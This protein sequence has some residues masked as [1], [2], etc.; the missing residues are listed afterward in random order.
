VRM[1]TDP[2]RESDSSEWNSILAELQKEAELPLSD[3]ARSL[4]EAQMDKAERD[5]LLL[6]S[7]VENDTELSDEQRAS[8]LRSA[9]SALVMNTRI[10]QQGL[11]GIARGESTARAV[12]NARTAQES[13][14]QLFATHMGHATITP[15]GMETQSVAPEPESPAQD[16]VDSSR[17]RGSDIARRAGI[18]QEETV[19]DA[20]DAG[21]GTRR[22]TRAG[23]TQKRGD[24]TKTRAAR[25]GQQSQEEGGGATEE[26]AEDASAPSPFSPVNPRELFGRAQVNPLEPGVTSSEVGNALREELV[27]EEA[28][29]AAEGITAGEPPIA[30]ETPEQIRARLDGRVSREQAEQAYKD[31]DAVFAGVEAQKKEAYLAALTEY[32]KS[33]GFFDAMGE[34]TGIK[35]SNQSTEPA[36]LKALKREWMQA[37]LSRSRMRLSTVLERRE[38]RG[39]SLSEEDREAKTLRADQVLER[40]QRRY[41]LREAASVAI[42]AA[43]EEAHVRAEALSNRDRNIVEKVFKWTK[44]HPKTMLLFSTLATGAGVATTAASLTIA[45]PLAVLISAGAAVSAVNRIRAQGKAEQATALEKKEGVSAERVAKIRAEQ[46]RLQKN[47]AKTT[48]AGLTSLLFG[49][50]ANKLFG[51]D[52]A[53]AERAIVRA[54]NA[55]IGDLRSDT[56]LEEL[57]R[58]SQDLDKAYA[59][60]RQ[61]DARI[62]SASVVG[63]VVGGY[64]GGAAAGWVASQEVVAG[65]VGGAADFVQDRLNDFSFTEAP[66]ADAPQLQVETAAPSPAAESA[67]GTVAESA[68]APAEG[69]SDPAKT[70]AS[71]AEAQPAPV[72]APVAAA[73]GAAAA[74]PAVEGFAQ[75]GVPEGLLV[76]ATIHRA[77]EGFGDMIVDLKENFREQLGAVIDTPKPA[78]EYVLSANANEITH[79][80]GAAENGQSLTMQMGDQF[81]I[82]ENQNIWFQPING[83]PHLVIENVPVTAEHPDGFV[84]HKL[85]TEGDM[86]ADVMP[87][88]APATPATPAAAASSSAEAPVPVATVDAPTPVAVEQSI[89][90]V[91]V[92][93]SVELQPGITIPEQLSTQMPPEAVAPAV[94]AEAPSAA[95]A[96]PAAPE[97]APAA[98]P[99]YEIV[100]TAHPFAQPD[101]GPFMNENGVDLNKPQILMNENRYFALG[102]NN[103]DSFARAAAQSVALSRTPGAETT[104]VY[105]VVREINPITDEPYLAVRMAFTPPNA[106]TALVAPYGPGSRPVA[107]LPDASKFVLPTRR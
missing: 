78:L 20:V 28:R 64:G 77:G 57:E 75:P 60:M 8:L 42:K 74:G 10:R 100:G 66:Q 68:A 45:S 94:P 83:E 69:V 85:D 79:A 61:A 102:T 23:S 53:S 95:P 40:F 36:E 76:G 1:Q 16:V 34:R 30:K 101:A 49:G 93:Q 72:A 81:A 37:R 11:S 82:D 19:I 18:V 9:K 56:A 84:I 44:D 6:R 86:R 39:A 41:L 26:V 7:R 12:E 29:L 80:I 59:K 51:K 48:V 2:P 46:A 97:A 4:I 38:A 33:R 22:G 25:A 3:K 52:K 70:A 67:S 32:Q 103:E 31:K 5:L 35:R 92:S 98:A 43:E 63:G 47:A 90:G 17:V 106:D 91:S 58:L 50:A 88:Q 96:A 13:F 107:D 105:F 62:A 54:G 73:E 87:I 99:Q 14:E 21:G 27:A 15:R 89:A 55:E 71:A 65:T 104:N 24:K